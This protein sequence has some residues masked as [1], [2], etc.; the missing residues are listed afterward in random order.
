MPGWYKTLHGKP[1]KTDYTALKE[2]LKTNLSFLNK[3][4]W[5]HFAK[6]DLY[7]LMQKKGVTIGYHSWRDLESSGD[8]DKVTITK[9]LQVANF[10][11]VTINEIFN[12]DLTTAYRSPTRSE[13]NKL[14]RLMD[15]D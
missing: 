10:Y 9:L 7:A 11:H 2:T 13:A 1:A 14:L 12:P 4:H 5:A 15:E 6:R 3:T 8:F